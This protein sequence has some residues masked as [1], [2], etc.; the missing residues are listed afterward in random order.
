MTLELQVVDAF[1][2]KAFSGNPA[3]VAV[4]DDFP[5]EQRMQDVAREMALSETAFCVAR[6]DGDYDLRWFTPTVEVDLCGHATLATAHV[7]QASARF[8]TRSGVLSCERGPDGLMRIDLPADPPEPAPIPAGLPFDAVRSFARTR[9]D[10]LVE[11]A[12]A[13][14]VRSL[15]PDLQ[16]VA[17]VGGRCVVVTAAGDRSGVDCVSRVFAPNV[18]IPEDPVTGSAHCA[19]AVFWG[20]R[21]GRHALVGEQASSRGGTVLMERRGDRVVLGGGAVTVSRVTL[22]V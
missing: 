13:S 15:A 17:A 20:D 12:D 10:L 11:L 14:A 22:L 21:L 2:D 1:T 19:L 3:A 4:V 16:A 8:H 5:S 9:S 6:A 18:G 7:L